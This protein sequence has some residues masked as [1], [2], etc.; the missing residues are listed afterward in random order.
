MGGAAVPVDVGAVRLVVDHIGFGAQ[1]VEY[2]LGDGGGAAV[3]AVQADAV[4][5]KGPG[6]QGN[7]IA[8][9]AVSSGHIVC[10]AADV[11]PAGQGQF[12]DLS[13][14]VGLDLVLDGR[15]DFLAGTADDLDS[16]I[17][18]G[19]MAGGN[20]NAAVKLIQTHHIGHA[21][22]GGY[23]EQI[24]IGSGSGQSRGQRVLKHI[25]GPSGILADDDPGLVL[26]SIVPSQETSY[27]KRMLHCQTYVGLSPEAVSS[28]IL[29]H[30]LL[31]S[32][33]YALSFIFASLAAWSAAMQASTI[34]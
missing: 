22:G 13:V 26:L 30:I 10:G 34:S 15:L 18:V 7:Q 1:G 28:K 11:I 21:G 19:V 6:G 9:V 8:D 23:M 2:A 3:G 5:L 17:I 14:N 16:V 27:F 32:R 24:G 20:H 29:S 33:A 12:P 4:I 31:L 25:A